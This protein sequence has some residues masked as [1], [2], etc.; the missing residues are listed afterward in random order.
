MLIHEL[1]GRGSRDSV[2]TGMSPMSVDDFDG[3]PLL[4]FAVD[5][6]PDDLTLLRRALQ[7]SNPHAVLQTA[8]SVREAT[9]QLEA[10]AGESLQEQ[11]DVIVLDLNIAGGSGHDLLASIKQ[12]PALA[13]IP[14]VIYSG[15]P[16]VGDRARAARLGSAGYLEKMPASHDLAQLIRAITERLGNR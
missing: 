9:L 16:N 8:G 13:H 10:Y 5:D 11:P 7:K 4:V 1:P 2:A 6:E 3:E 15:S 12:N 14:V